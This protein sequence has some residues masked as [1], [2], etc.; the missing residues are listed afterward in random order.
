ML[1]IPSISTK[2]AN[3]PLSVRTLCILE[4]AR[5]TLFPSGAWLPFLLETWEIMQTVVLF[6]VPSGRL[7]LG[8]GTIP[9]TL[10]RTKPRPVVPVL[11][12]SRPKKVPRV[13][14]C[15]R[16]Q[17]ARY[18]TLARAK[19][20]RRSFLLT[21]MAQCEPILLELALF[22]TAWCMLSLQVVRA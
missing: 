12:P 9:F 17:L 6:L 11:P 7:H 13:P 14:L 18:L 8:L 22:W 2:W 16:L 5:W 10:Q 4:L 3:P 1:L 19:F 20:V 21:A 15:V